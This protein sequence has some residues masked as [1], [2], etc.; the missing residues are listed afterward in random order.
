ML[1]WTGGHAWCDVC[2][3]WL[4]LLQPPDRAHVMQAVPDGMRVVPLFVVEVH[5]HVR[6][7]CFNSVVARHVC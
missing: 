7:L 1:L 4:C 5:Q 2:P 6:W 3:A